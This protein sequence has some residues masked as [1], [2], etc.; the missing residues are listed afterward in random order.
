METWLASGTSKTS[1]SSPA[2][3]GVP[4]HAG[5]TPADSDPTIYECRSS[6]DDTDRAG[7]AVFDEG[8]VRSTGGFGLGVAAERAVGRCVARSRAVVEVTAGDTRG[9]VRAV[10]V[11]LAV[12]ATA[13]SAIDLGDAFEV[14]TAVLVARASGSNPRS[15]RVFQTGLPSPERATIAGSTRP[16]PPDR[17]MNANKSSPHGPSCGSLADPFVKRRRGATCRASAGRDATTGFAC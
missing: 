10:R 16:D 13:V 11:R 5:T 4:P 7:G 14:G 6:A 9:L 8:D 15:L 1:A 3:S 2:A 12:A 17:W